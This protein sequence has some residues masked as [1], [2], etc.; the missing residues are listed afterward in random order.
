V[1][2]VEELALEGPLELGMVQVAGVQ[3]EVVGVNWNGRILEIDD[4]LDT[5]AL[6]ARGK[7]EQGVLIQLELGKDTVETRMGRTRHE[8]DCKAGS[9][10]R[11][12]LRCLPDHQLVYVQGSCTITEEA[13]LTETTYTTLR[14]SLA[15]VLDRVANDREV[16]VI[17]RRGA[18]TVALIPADEL[19][20]LIETAHLL[21]SPKN[22][23]RLLSALKRAAG[24]KGKP[25]PLEKLRREL[26]LGA[27]R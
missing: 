8:L 19:M 15:S 23:D 22:A 16:F 18:K 9:S 2:A 6:F 1:Q 20:G 3:I 11:S 27:D 21:R 5:L 10:P 24:R 4:D 25:E 17:R 12:A 7:I 13:C 14:Q 26:G